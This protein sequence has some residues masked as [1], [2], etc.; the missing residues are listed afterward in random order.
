MPLT[1]KII[2]AAQPRARLYKLADSD[3]L[4]LAIHPSGGKHWRFKYRYGGKDTTL[5]LGGYPAISLADAR[6]LRDDTKK[7][8]ADGR[9]PLAAKVEAKYRRPRRASAGSTVFQLALADDGSLTI[10]TKASSLQLSPQQV[11]ALR[12]FLSVP[13][14]SDD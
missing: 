14:P 2:E 5:S 8:L 3:G 1:T 4:S 9:D 11:A 13:V 6:R 7:L 12:Q 10:Q